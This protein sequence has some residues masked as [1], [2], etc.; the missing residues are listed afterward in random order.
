MKATLLLDAHSMAIEDVPVPVPSEGEV[1]LRVHSCGICGTDMEFYET[2]AYNPR[3]ILGHECSATIERVGPGV[4]GWKPGDRV[5]VNDLFSCGECDFCLRGLENL[6]ASAANLGIHWQGAFA[7][8]TKVPVRSLFRLPENISMRDGALIPTLAVGYH[9]TRQVQLN[10]DTK[11]LIIGA[12]PVGLSILAALKVAGVRKVAV[13]D[14]NPNSR[15]VAARLGASAVI[16]PAHE[17]LP[18]RLEELFSSQP[19]LVFEAAGRPATILEAMDSV[20]RG[21]TAVIVGNCFEEITVNPIT[22]ILK[23]IRIHA[24]QG[25]TTEDFSTTIGW[26]SE[27]QVDADSFITRTI[28]LDELPGVMRELTNAKSDIKIV[29]SI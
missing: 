10:P 27:G 17:N 19:R 25:T 14:I 7:E 22:W 6:C 21:G 9:V 2:G 16:D 18:E 3:M 8:Y 11:T 20:E 29:V 5:V 28:S 1:L 12:G 23:E 15:E 13:S 26:M 24:S 4:A